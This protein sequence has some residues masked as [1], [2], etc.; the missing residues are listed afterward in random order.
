METTMLL[1]KYWIFLVFVN[2]KSS[3]FFFGQEEIL[4]QL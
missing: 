4:I 3:D 2:W 1:L